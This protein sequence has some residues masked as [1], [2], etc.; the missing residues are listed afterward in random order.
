MFVRSE[1]L[2]EEAKLLK[3]WKG[4]KQLE[5]MQQEKNSGK[6]MLKPSLSSFKILCCASTP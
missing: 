5:V 3:N 1:R 2:W 4:E 6:V